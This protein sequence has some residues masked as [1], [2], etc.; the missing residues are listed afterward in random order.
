MFYVWWHLSRGLYIK[1]FDNLGFDVHFTVAHALH[2]DAEG[3]TEGRD[4][5]VHRRDQAG[6]GSGPDLRAAG[7][8]RALDGR[9]GRARAGPKRSFLGR[10][11]RR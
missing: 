6:H 1:L 7:R 2:H 5:A 8:S 11:Q 9:A 10:L 4:A 3:G